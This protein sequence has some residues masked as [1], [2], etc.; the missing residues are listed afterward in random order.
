MAHALIRAVLVLTAFAPGPVGQPDP[1]RPAHSVTERLNTVNSRWRW[2]KQAA[3]TGADN[4]LI[5]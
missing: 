4:R 3:R 5:P 2:R 1:Q